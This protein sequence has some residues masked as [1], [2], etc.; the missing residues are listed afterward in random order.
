M[1]MDLYLWLSKRLINLFIANSLQYWPS[2]SL[3]AQQCCSYPMIWNHKIKMT[4]SNF[5]SLPVSSYILHI[6]KSYYRKGLK[7]CAMNW[8]SEDS[9]STTAISTEVSGSVAL[10][11]NP[12]LHGVF[13]VINENNQQFATLTLYKVY[14]Y[15]LSL[16]FWYDSFLSFF[17]IKWSPDAEYRHRKAISSAKI[18]TEYIIK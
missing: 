3:K 12:E 8:I 2:F 4:F 10:Q 17:L 5:K 1:S 15:K 7:V 6:K 16:H 14:F 13:I 11:H 18:I 9:C